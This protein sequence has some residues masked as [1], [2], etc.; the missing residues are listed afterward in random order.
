MALR[1]QRGKQPSNRPS[2]PLD[3]VAS[4]SNQRRPAPDPMVNNPGQVTVNIDLADDAEYVLGGLP[5][6]GAMFELRRAA[7]ERPS[8]SRFRVTSKA[9]LAFTASVLDDSS[10]NAIFTV[11]T[12]QGIEVQTGQWVKA[13]FDTN[14]GEGQNQ[15]MLVV[16]QT[17]TTIECT[18]A[19]TA[20]VAAAGA[21]TL[22]FD[23]V[24][25]PVES[26]GVVLFDSIMIADNQNADLGTARKGVYRV[27]FLSTTSR[28]GIIGSVDAVATSEYMNINSTDEENV[29]VEEATSDTVT[30]LFVSSGQVLLRNGADVA[31]KM[32]VTFW[33]A[34]H[35]GLD[36]DGQMCLFARNGALRL[37][38]R[39]GAAVTDLVLS[40]VA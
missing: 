1:M 12:P 9:N 13:V 4:T 28:M 40:R 33:A 38:N 19:F 14:P 11:A 30:S 29:S 5:D 21:G 18:F 31:A 20:D 37:R 39:S 32:R 8:P 25:F 22:Q 34:E 27:E 15:Y 17:A 6:E 16:D 2:F 7:D 36:Q 10:N 24:V 3:V 26:E 23:A 35:S